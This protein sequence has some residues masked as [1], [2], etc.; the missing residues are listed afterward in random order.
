MNGAFQKHFYHCHT[1]Q[2]N[3]EMLFAN[4]ARFPFTYSRMFPDRLRHVLFETCATESRFLR[5]VYA[6]L[7]WFCVQLDFMR[8]IRRNLRWRDR[9]YCLV[10]LAYSFVDYFIES[11]PGRCRG[12]AA[13]CWWWAWA[14]RCRST[15]SGGRKCT[16][17]CRRQTPC[18]S[19]PRSSC[20]RWRSR[21]VGG[22]VSWW[23]CPPGTQGI[24]GCSKKRQP[25]RRSCLSITP[26]T[27]WNWWTSASSGGSGP[28][29]I[30]WWVARPYNLHCGTAEIRFSGVRSPRL[31]VSGYC[32]K[33]QIQGQ[34]W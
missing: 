34:F 19:R 7:P 18:I 27:W 25:W 9:C 15:R 4:D 31:W 21:P 29:C 1:I 24:S 33:W 22:W 26:S 28:F 20:R 23:I 16:A 5:T 14:P 8:T 10:C 17:C 30:I 12:C 13:V 2:Q 11:A 32:T 6:S 3:T